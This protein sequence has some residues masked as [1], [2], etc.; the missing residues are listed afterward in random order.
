MAVAD[1][2]GA[3]NPAAADAIKSHF[4]MNDLLTGANSIEEA[5]HVRQII[6]TSLAA[7]GF[8]LRKYQSNAVEVLDTIPKECIESKSAYEFGDSWAIISI[9]G[10]LG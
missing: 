4:Y 5:N 7:A 6:H 3:D 8:E 10:L 1:T 2:I 9:L